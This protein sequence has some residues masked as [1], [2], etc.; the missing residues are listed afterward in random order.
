M[1]AI[2]AEL[3]AEAIETLQA[4]GVPRERVELIRSVDLRYV[5][6]FN[7]VEVPRAEAFHDRHEVLYGYSMPGAPTELINLRL[8]A[9]GITQ[10]PRLRGSEPGGED[11]SAA[12]KGHREAYFDGGF[13]SVGVYDGLKLVNGN[14]VPGPAIIEQPTTTIVL[15][16]D[17]VASCDEYDNY[18]VEPKER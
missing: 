4:E 14:V 17:F 6:Q 11:P 3:E 5:G 8:S 1:D 2:Y 7:E 12:L 13:E 18:R 15:P 9:R 10:K 16:A